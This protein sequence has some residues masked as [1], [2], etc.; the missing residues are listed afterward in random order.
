MTSLSF[1]GYKSLPLCDDIKV[2]DVGLVFVA[3]NDQ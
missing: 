1:C 3:G 2:S